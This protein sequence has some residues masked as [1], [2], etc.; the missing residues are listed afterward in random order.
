MHLDQDAVLCRQAFL[1][2]LV[3]LVASFLFEKL[4]PYWFFGVEI[5]ASCKSWLEFMKSYFPSASVLCLYQAES[6]PIYILF[7]MVID[8]AITIQDN[9]FGKGCFKKDPAEKFMHLKQNRVRQK[10][11]QTRQKCKSGQPIIARHRLPNLSFIL[12]GLCLY[13]HQ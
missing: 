6:V 11:I 7:C 4:S 3:P 1:L 10:R 2:L 9:N 8:T 5:S 13:S 12:L